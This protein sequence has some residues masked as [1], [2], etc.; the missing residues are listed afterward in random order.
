MKKITFLF[1]SLFVGSAHAIPTT[2]SDEA[3]F[4]G[5]AGSLSIESF[6][7]EV[8][9]NSRTLSSLSLT[10]FDM[11]MS[12]GGTM[13]IFTGDFFGGHATDGVNYAGFSDGHAFVDYAFDSNINSFGINFTDFGDFGTGSV[14]FSNNI[15]DVFTAAV[16]GVPNANEQFFGLIT[17]FNFTNVRLSQNIGGE[18]YAVDEIYYGT[19]SVPEPSSLVLIGL[20]LAGI[21]FSRKM[22]NN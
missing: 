19:T 10:D 17:D 5:A 6:E 7:G 8:A 13:G 20:G 2:Y 12:G 18:F 14:T 15:G 4:L 21:G 22:K 3:S 9:T 1:V 16:S 11:I